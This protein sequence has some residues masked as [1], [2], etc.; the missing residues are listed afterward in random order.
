MSRWICSGSLESARWASSSSRTPVVG[1]SLTTSWSGS[2]GATPGVEAE[3][4]RAL[5][6]E[7]QLGLRDRQA[8]A[9]ADEERA[10]PTSASCR[11]PGAAPR[12]SRWSSR[13][14]RRRC[15]GSRR[16]GRARS[17]PGRPPGIARNTRVHRVLERRRSSPARGLHRRRGDD[18]HEVV[19]HDVAQR[20]DR[21]VEV[22]AVLDAEALGHRDL[23]RGEVV[24]VPD[25][26]EHRV[27]EAQVE[28]LRR[29]PSS[30]GSGRCGT[31][32][33]RRC[34]WWISVGQRAGGGQVVAERLLHDDARVLGQPCLRE[35]LDH[36]AEEERRDLEVEDRAASRP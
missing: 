20:A 3:A 7:P 11:S 21:V 1:S 26:L 10:R 35:A 2:G 12:R 4:R 36:R 19:D 5:E 18:L 27:R 31:A 16:T 29:A 23:H 9:G 30:R 13:P 32:A 17:A 25:R 15:R 8:L 34:S 22:A 14:R 33:T 24:A 6:H 28:D